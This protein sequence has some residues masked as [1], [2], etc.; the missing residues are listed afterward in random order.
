MLPLTR[1]LI[2]CEEQLEKC[3]HNI[4]V[5]KIILP[6]R[7]AQICSIPSTLNWV[8]N[9]KVLT[10]KIEFGDIADVKSPEQNQM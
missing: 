2:L 10:G 1:F 4:N 7:Y 3:T 6:K 5:L 9:R 8:G